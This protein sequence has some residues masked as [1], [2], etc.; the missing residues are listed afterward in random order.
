MDILSLDLCYKKCYTKYITNN[1]NIQQVVKVGGIFIAM[2]KSKYDGYGQIDFTE[3]GHDSDFIAAIANHTDKTLK[4][5]IDDL[6]GWYS[7]PVTVPPNDW[8]GFLADECGCFQAESIKNGDF[9]AV[10]L[11]CESN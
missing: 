9:K 8:V 6:E 2:V 1:K 5:Y 11:P 4:V 3:T 7:E 10:Y